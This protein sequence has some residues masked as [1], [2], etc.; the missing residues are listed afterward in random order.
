MN[1]ITSTLE[2]L[3][4][5]EKEIKIYLAS[6]TIWQATSSILWNKAWISRTT[7]QH[8]CK[9]LVSKRLLNITPQKSWTIYSAEEPEKLIVLVNNKYSQV[10][11]MMKNTHDIMSDLKSLSNPNSRLPKVK[12][13]TG[14]DGIIDMLDDVLK[15]KK[16]L[17]GY[18]KVGSNINTEILDYL[19]NTYVYKREK[20]WIKSMWIINEDEIFR[21]Y[22]NNNNTIRNDIYVDEE[23][24]PFECCMHIY[25]D[26]VAFFTYF[27]DDMSWVIIENKRI[28]SSQ[29]TLFKLAYKY[30]KLLNKWIKDESIV[31]L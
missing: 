18:L 31:L 23:V 29:M 17:Y 28:A 19:K 15:D 11:R 30:S 24:Y 22:K 21:N 2:S 1:K 13:Y 6:L 25:W 4:L 27:D 12:Y 7:A 10:E 20:A 5:N 14:V 8:I 3:W 26:K 9:S 16:D